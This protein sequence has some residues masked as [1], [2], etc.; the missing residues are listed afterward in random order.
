[1][2]GFLENTIIHDGVKLDNLI[3]IAHNVVIGENSAIA[4]WGACAIAGLT[5]I[6]NNFRM[7]GLS[8][9]LG[10]LSIC[11]DVTVG[12]H[13]LITKDINQSGEYIGIMPAQEKRNG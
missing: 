7:G 5:K 1:M 2:I 10:H 9:V 3:H 12:V 11:D 13:T 8:G 4:G 6:G